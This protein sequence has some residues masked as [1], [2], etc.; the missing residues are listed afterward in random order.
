M[1]HMDGPRGRTKLV[2]V[3]EGSG[4]CSRESSITKRNGGQVTPIRKHQALQQW[5][6][7]DNQLDSP[8]QYKTLKM[9]L[10]I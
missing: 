7:G 2:P 5:F 3:V 8:A 10:P 4:E 6:Y 9:V 1:G